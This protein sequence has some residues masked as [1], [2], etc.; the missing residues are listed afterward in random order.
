MNIVLFF[1]RLRERFWEPP[2]TLQSRKLWFYRRK[3][4]VFDGR[5]CVARASP[6]STLG[7]KTKP[8]CSQKAQKINEKVNRKKHSKK[9]KKHAKN[10]SQMVPRGSPGGFF[11]QLLGPKGGDRIKFLRSWRPLPSNFSFSVPPGSP[12]TSPRT[13]PGTILD[14]IWDF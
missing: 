8:K 3:S 2:G 4:M 14:H 7:A 6:G 11:L 1:K 12:G 9:I 13:T 5:P 10:G